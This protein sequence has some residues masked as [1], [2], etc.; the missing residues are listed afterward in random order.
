MSV[1]PSWKHRCIY[2]YRQESRV[3]KR[4]CKDLKTHIHKKALFIVLYMINKTHWYVNWSKGSN[5]LIAFYD[6]RPAQTHSGNFVTVSA[7][8][9]IFSCC[10]LRL[11]N[12]KL[13]AA[14]WT[15]PKTVYN[16]E[17]S[18]WASVPWL[19][20]NLLLIHNNQCQYIMALTFDP[21]KCSWIF[22][23]NQ[24]KNSVGVVE[25]SHPGERDGQTTVNNMINMNRSTGTSGSGCVGKGH[26]EKTWRHNKP[27]E[28]KCDMSA[29]QQLRSRLWFNWFQLITEEFLPHSRVLKPERSHQRAVHIWALLFS[30]PFF[31]TP[32]VG[33]ISEEI[34]LTV[35]VRQ[36]HRS[37]NTDAARQILSNEALPPPLIL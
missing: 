37:S 7:A 31:T 5:L 12:V 8:T 9:H 25:T 10:S 13:K 19:A 16:Q 26:T 20:V 24:K 27:E 30:L 15:L 22:V 2:I 32:P 18:L 1:Y 28:Q 3:G 29:P 33:D 6:Q 4:R 14:D 36:C 21:F 17:A 34:P 23:L 11:I 35:N